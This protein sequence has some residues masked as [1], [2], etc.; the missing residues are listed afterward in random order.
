[1]KEVIDQHVPLSKP[2]PF[3]V[4]WWSEEIGRLVEEAR[5]AFRRR[6]RNPT[7]LAWQEYLEA[8]RAKGAAIR[9]ENRQCFE[10]V[11]QNVCKEGGKSF[12]KLAKWAKSKSIL[13]LT[14]PSI[15]SL[16]T[17]QGP[18]TTLEAKCDTLRARS[19][20]PIPPA[21]LSDIPEFH[22]LAEKSSPP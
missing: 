6:R 1:M 3:R 10:E 17:P 8:K 5:R 11:I 4:P 16:T 15:P 21:D 12:W 20:P 14:P 13:P 19:F 22:Y 18:A 7:E 2:A 9:Q